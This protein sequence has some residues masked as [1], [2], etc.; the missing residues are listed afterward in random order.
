VVTRATACE[1]LSVVRPLDEIDVVMT[2]RLGRRSYELGYVMT[3]SEDARTVAR[4]SLTLAGIDRHGRATLVPAP[5]RD[6]LTAAT[7]A[8]GTPNEKERL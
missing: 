7:A 1:Y 4:A 3:R 5:V 6:L 8:M 2:G